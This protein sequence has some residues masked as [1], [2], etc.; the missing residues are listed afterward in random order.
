MGVDVGGGGKGGV[1]QPL[2]DL[3]HWD[4]LAEQQTGTAVAQVMEPDVPQAVLLQ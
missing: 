2:L 3:L 1:S 4:T